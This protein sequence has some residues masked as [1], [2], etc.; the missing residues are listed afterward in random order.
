MNWAEIS[1]QTTTEGIEI[2]T[3]FLMAHGVNQ[4][5]IEDAADFQNFL[6]DTTVYWDYVDE[7]L[8]EKM[9][10]CDTKVKFYL[11]DTPDGYETLSQIKSDL[12]RLPAAEE[13][14]DLGPL[15]VEVVYKE[16][17][18]WETAWQKYYHPIEIS[19]NLI[20]VP[21]WE[22]VDLKPGQKQLLLNPG[23]AFGTGGHNT[24]RLV[25]SMLDKLPVEGEKVLDMGCGSGILSIAAL[26]LGAG[27]VTA[28]D[29][30]PLAVKIA[31]ENAELNG[32]QD[33]RLAIIA[34]NVLTDDALADQLAAEPVDL[35]LANI[36]AD[37]LI[38]M[39]P[40]FVRCLKPGGDLIISGI[41]TER[42]EEVLSVMREYGFAVADQQEENGWCAAR[43]SH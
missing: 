35:I 37:V 39:A 29:I 15:T 43:L 33:E 28:V 7:G 23:M 6:S 4:V 20:I 36:V 34:G 40:L 38:G 26:L 12:T 19:D 30:D 2:V 25:L 8:M 14:I 24:T 21:E 1:I 9:E 22:K 17:E 18:E 11:T 10:H 3:G 27:A 41:I 42:A 31:G 5:M 16:Q 32:V 13:G